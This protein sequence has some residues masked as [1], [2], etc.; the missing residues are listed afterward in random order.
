MSSS[1]TLPDNTVADAMANSHSDTAMEHILQGIS[2]VGR[3][4]ETMDSKITDLS[5]D[6]KSIRVD[7]ASFQ[8]TVS[9]LDHRLHA[10]ENQMASLPDNKPKLQYL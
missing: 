4:L 9:E 7:I 3:C 8:A 2:A 6:S 5:A 1:P 10:I